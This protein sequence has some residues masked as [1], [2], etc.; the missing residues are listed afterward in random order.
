M[1]KFL[2]TIFPVVK[3]RFT[4]LFFSLCLSIDINRAIINL[5]KL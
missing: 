5:V 2:T 3:I 4:A 1:Y